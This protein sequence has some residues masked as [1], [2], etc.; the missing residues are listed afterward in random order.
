VEGR[1]RLT[2]ERSGNGY[3]EFVMHKP[4]RAGNGSEQLRL[5]GRSC[6]ATYRLAIFFPPR[7]L[8]GT[9]VWLGRSPYSLKQE[10]CV[11]ARPDH[12]PS[13]R[14]TTECIGPHSSLFG[15]VYPTNALFGTTYMLEMVSSSRV[16][17][18]L[19]SRDLAMM[20]EGYCD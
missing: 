8:N 14:L 16:M 5:G 13:F 19:G 17:R 3:L 20:E 7:H 12:Q 15:A 9:L 2:E 4:K 1:S 10:K 18:S 6:N 11:I